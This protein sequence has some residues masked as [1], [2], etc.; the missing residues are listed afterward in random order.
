MVSH[1]A[2]YLARIWANPE[3]VRGHRVSVFSK[4]R[5]CRPSHTKGKIISSTGLELN[6]ISRLKLDL[7][8]CL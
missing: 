7:Y 4:A 8:V 5:D 6:C 1:R 2:D 3:V